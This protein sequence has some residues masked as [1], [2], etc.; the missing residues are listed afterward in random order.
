MSDAACAKGGSVEDMIG[1]HVGCRQGVDWR[2]AASMA[3]DRLSLSAAED[4]QEDDGEIRAKPMK[5]EPV[6]A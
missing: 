3:G 6:M 5:Q 1:R 2:G 4:M